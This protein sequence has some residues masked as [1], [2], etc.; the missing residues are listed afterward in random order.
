MESNLETFVGVAAALCTTASYIPQL[1]K[2]WTTGETGDLS[3]KMLLLLACGLGLWLVYGIM[4][5]DAVIILANGVSL[6][7]LGCILYFKLRETYGRGEP[8]R[9]KA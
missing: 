4:R 3:L 7:L 2:C 1:R 5:G 9:Q 8:H 6:A